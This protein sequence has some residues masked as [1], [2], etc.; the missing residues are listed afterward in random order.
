MKWE[1][2]FN[3]DILKHTGAAILLVEEVKEIADSKTYATDYIDLATEEDKQY[4][5][6][7][8]HGIFTVIFEGH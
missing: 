1:L 4:F 5:K 6:Q 3:P 7:K 2:D 8:L